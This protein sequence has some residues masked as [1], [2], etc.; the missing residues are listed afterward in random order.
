MVARRFLFILV[1]LAVATTL[2]SGPTGA[3]DPTCDGYAW[4]N[5]PAQCLTSEDG[6]VT[7]KTGRRIGPG[8]HDRQGVEA[9]MVVAREPGIA[10]ISELMKG[11][12]RAAK[13]VQLSGVATA[14]APLAGSVHAQRVDADLRPTATG[15]ESVELEK[16]PPEYVE[17][18]IW[19]G[20]RPTT[21]QVRDNQ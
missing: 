21:Y 20:K 14:F 2:A 1:P 19:R 12:D 11:A 8:S 5:Y 6:A 16:L 17:V 7:T 9:R 18:T 15:E 4:P 10:P 13:L 3:S